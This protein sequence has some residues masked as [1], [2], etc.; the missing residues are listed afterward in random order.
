MWGSAGPC[1]TG[2]LASMEEK[3]ERRFGRECGF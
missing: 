3:G 1:P 2:V